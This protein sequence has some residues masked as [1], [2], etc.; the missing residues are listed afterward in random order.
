MITISKKVEYSIILIS[1]LAKR[2]GE[3]VSLADVSQKLG[4]PYRFLG[5]LAGALK[6]GGLVDS[7]EGKSGGYSLNEGWRGK[8]LYDLLEALGE[9][10]HMVKCLAGDRV[11]ERE[12]DCG[13]KKVWNKMEDSFTKELKLIKL[14]DL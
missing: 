3:T 9:N 5:Q 13:L 11:C 8:T 2:E 4:L 14:A 12:A 10:K 7:R 6:S 1:Y